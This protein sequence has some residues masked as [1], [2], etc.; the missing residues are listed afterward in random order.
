MLYIDNKKEEED[1]YR[2]EN[3]NSDPESGD[4][5]SFGEVDQGID[6]G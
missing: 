2:V 6:L 4:S 1:I 3:E 5:S